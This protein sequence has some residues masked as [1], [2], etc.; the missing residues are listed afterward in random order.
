MIWTKRILNKNVRKYFDEFVH[1]KENVRIDAL[2]NEGK[3]KM[4]GQ[5]E[6]KKEINSESV[7]NLNATT[8]TLIH[9]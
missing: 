8:F 5:K 3:N 4:L 1:I 2:K 6:K 7:V 9:F